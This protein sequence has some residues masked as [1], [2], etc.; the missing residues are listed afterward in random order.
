[1]EPR[2]SRQAKDHVFVDM[3]NQPKY[4]LELFKA[5]HPEATDITEAD[6]Q[7]IT[8]SHVI[9]DKPYNDLGFTVKGRQLVLAEAQTSWSF[10]ILIRLLLYFVDTLLGYIKEHPDLDVH[11]TARLPLP[12]PEFYV[13]YTGDRKNVPPMI[14]IRKD[15]FKEETVPF[16]L[17]AHVI[18]TES[19]DDIIGQYILFTHVFDQQVKRYGYTRKAAEETVRICKDKGVLKGY[20]EAHET[21]VVNSMIMLFEQEESVKRYGNRMR[22]E[23][24][25]EGR[26]E[27]KIVTLCELVTDGMLTIEQAAKKAGMTVEQFKAAVEALKVTA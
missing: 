8:I 12:I 24:R 6:I 15:F 3:F 9:V 19:T 2:P 27:G 23:G 17:E 13:I 1:M 4:C 26:D 25:A 14:S 18:S 22:S 5:L 11:S 10:N 20:L 16:D 7:N 21:E